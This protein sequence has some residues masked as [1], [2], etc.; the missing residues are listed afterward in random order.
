MFLDEIS[1]L[2]GY[3]QD[4]I[5]LNSSQPISKVKD[6]GN[7]NEINS[8]QMEGYLDRSREVQ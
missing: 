8:L 7:G 2:Y 4:Q 6:D 5:C 1:L 3:N